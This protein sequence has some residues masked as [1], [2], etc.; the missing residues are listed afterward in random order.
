M[1]MRDA[2]AVL[3]VITA[4]ATTPAAQAAPLDLDTTTPMLTAAGA[5][6]DFLSF[7][8]DGD[9]STF[10]AEVTTFDGIVS[11]APADISFGVG[12]SV[13]NPV[14]SFSGGLDIFD[15]VGVFLRGDIAAIGFAEDL[16]EFEFDNLSGPGIASFGNSVLLSIDFTDSLGANPFDSLVDGQSYEASLTLANVAAIPTPAVLP[17]LLAGLGAFGLCRLVV[18]GRIANEWPR[19]GGAAY[20]SENYSPNLEWVPRAG[21]DQAA[22]LTGGR[23]CWSSDCSGLR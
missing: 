14:T 17:L 16:I 4:L 3:A 21:Q 6:V 9:L 13:A 18:R 7:D 5:F 10:F 1:R 11:N 2:A 8:P 19:S 12:F 22:S 15:N 23:V 20:G